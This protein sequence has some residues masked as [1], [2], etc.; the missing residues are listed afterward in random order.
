M[1]INDILLAGAKAKGKR[2]YFFEDPAV[3][4]VL[5]ITMAVAG[6]LAVLRERLDTIERLL[7]AKGILSRAEIEA[8]RPDAKSEEERQRWHA[9]YIARILRIVQQEMEAIQDSPENNRTMDEVAEE[10]EKI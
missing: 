9:A 4:R 3:E 7:E 5:N 6:E 8:Y 2:P 1:E 10:L